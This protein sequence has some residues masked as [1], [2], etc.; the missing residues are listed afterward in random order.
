MLQ[1][2]FKVGGKVTIMKVREYPRKRT[3]T[4][5]AAQLRHAAPAQ[6]IVQKLE[7]RRS[8]CAQY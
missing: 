8:V 2:D 7:M 4:K 5:A 1:R 6:G 3:S